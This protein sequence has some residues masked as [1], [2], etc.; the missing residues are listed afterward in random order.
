MEAYLLELDLVVSPRTLPDLQESTGLF[1]SE[2]SDLEST[3]K[4]P[5]QYEKQGREV[6]ERIGRRKGEGGVGNPRRSEYPLEP[7]RRD[8]KGVR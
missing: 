5:K 8:E 7:L 3:G 1:H 2:A 6:V 4:E